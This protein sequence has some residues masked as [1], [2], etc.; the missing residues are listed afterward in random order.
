MKMI[1]KSLKV[2]SL[3]K[4]DKS[5]FTII[6]IE[7]YHNIYLVLFINNHTGIKYGDLFNE[8]DEFRI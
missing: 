3:I 7:I 5:E 1:V 4:N 2:G 8:L 6:D